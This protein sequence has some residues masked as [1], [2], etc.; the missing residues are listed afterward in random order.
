MTA[1]EGD[2]RTTLVSRGEEALKAF[3]SRDN[4]AHGSADVIDEMVEERHN[5]LLGQIQRQRGL[6]EELRGENTS[7][8][9]EVA[10]LRAEVRCAADPSSSHRGG[11]RLVPNIPTHH[12]AGASHF[13]CCG[14]HQR[15]VC[16]WTTARCHPPRTLRTSP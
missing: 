1:D 13:F 10:A 7:L 4:G 9:D 5:A 3:R 14:R 2:D 12:S 15:A 11:I 6:I 8:H 16:S